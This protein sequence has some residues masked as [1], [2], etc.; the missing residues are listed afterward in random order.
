[1]NGVESDQERLN[2]VTQ[3]ESKWYKQPSN[4]FLTKSE[5]A[6]LQ[7]LAKK[8]PEAAIKLRQSFFDD[9]KNNMN[10]DFSG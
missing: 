9:D 1:M 3:W 2:R 10:T 7:E 8:E 5:Y 4:Q 6:E